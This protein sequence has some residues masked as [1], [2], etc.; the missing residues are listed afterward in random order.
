MI[1]E[2]LGVLKGHCAAVWLREQASMRGLMVDHIVEST[3]LSTH[4]G[5]EPCP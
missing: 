1:E 2:L 4:G 3:S 5:A